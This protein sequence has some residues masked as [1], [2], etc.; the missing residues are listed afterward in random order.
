MTNQERSPDPSELLVLLAKQRDLYRSL[1]ELSEKQ[2]SM[3]SS[4]RPEQLINI[5][6]D[7]QGLV[8]SLARLNEEM[9]PFRRE[10]DTSYSSL[11]EGHRQQASELLQEING[12]LRVILQTDQEDSAMLS[13]RKQVVAKEMATLSGGQIA[14]TAY[15]RQAGSIAKSG[16]AD[17][18]G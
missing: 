4:N 6:R 11:P 15:A 8:T 9:G 12:L 3:I 1:R 14:N 10:W 16:T 5:L 17:V 18:T 13:A 2:R 7:R